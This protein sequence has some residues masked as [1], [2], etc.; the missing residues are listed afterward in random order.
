MTAN[1]GAIAATRRLRTPD[2]RLHPLQTRCT[3]PQR[4]RILWV[5]QQQP[6][7]RDAKVSF[8]AFQLNF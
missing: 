7:A 1:D 5:D 4:D 3:R 6:P 2:D 8:A